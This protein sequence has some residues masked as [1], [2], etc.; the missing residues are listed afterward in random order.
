M[1]LRRDNLAGGSK[2]RQMLPPVMDVIVIWHPS[3]PLGSL[4]GDAL[5]DH[6][7]GT[8]FSGLIGGAVEVYVRSAGWSSR[9]SAPRPI[10]FPAG[11]SAVGGDE[12][13]FIAV[14]PVMSRPMVDAVSDRGPWYDYVRQIPAAQAAHPDRVA[15]FPLTTSA[16]LGGSVLDSILGGRQR[17]GQVRGGK[18]VAGGPWR[19]DL[20]QG[21]T[22]FVHGPGSRIQ[23]FISHTRQSAGSAAAVTALT[24]LVATAISGSRLGEFF[25][26]RDLQPGE[27]W[28]ARLREAAGSSAVLALR[29]DLY[30]SRAWCQEEVRT[31]KLAGAPVVILDALM[32]GEERG[33][34]LMDHVPRV[35]VHRDEGDWS[36]HDVDRALSLLVD[37]ALKRALWRR[38]RE[39]A[40]QTAAVDVA[41]WAP[42]A[43]EP[44]TFADWLQEHPDEIARPGTDP[45]VV[46][47]PDPPLGDP[48][49]DVLGQFVRLAGS[50]RSLDIV[51]PR[52]LAARAG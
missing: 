46:L 49:C 22:Q 21:L 37:E 17:I 40:E 2:T 5:V 33:S 18:D 39:L 45:I 50:A 3:D 27:D 29:S 30:A 25:D 14:V 52:Q 36:R 12:P 11:A 26:A 31:A 42:H 24:E 13:R 28:A 10:S 43:P 47:H 8:I 38:Q 4:V 51:T 48:E 23:V 15:F 20:V 6:F 35:P 34:F 41:W 9:D 19:R 16:R 1:W 7:H 44:V 32:E